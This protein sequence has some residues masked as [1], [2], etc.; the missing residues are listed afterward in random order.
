MFTPKIV[1]VKIVLLISPI[2]F[3]L[4]A[5]MT[6]AAQLKPLEE[7]KPPIDSFIT[8]LNDPKYKSNDE[9]LKA[10]QRDQMLKIAKD[11]FDFEEVSKRA[12]SRNWRKFSVAEQKKF[13]EVFGSFIGYTYIDKIQG[14]YH[15]EKVVYGDEQIVDQKWALVRTKI[16]RETLEIPVDYKMKLIGG[17]WKVFD[18]LVEGVS[19]VKNYRTQFNSILRKEKPA[20]LIERLEK[21]SI[22]SK[23]SK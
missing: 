23:N 19:L 6:A 22:N 8:I 17:H 14:E 1:I 20:Q 2:F 9:S 5:S 11:I 18:V 12:L 4:T 3:L 21:K 16:K 13:T 10:Q 7:L 15:N